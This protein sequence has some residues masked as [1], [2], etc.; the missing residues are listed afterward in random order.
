M[1]L[2]ATESLSAGQRTRLETLTFASFVKFDTPAQNVEGATVLASGVTESGIRI[3][4]PQPTAF[5]GTYETAQPLRLEYRVA[6]S[7]V[8][9]GTEVLTVEPMRIVIE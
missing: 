7:S 4:F 3:R 2:F 1:R 6:G 8:E 5:R 9:E